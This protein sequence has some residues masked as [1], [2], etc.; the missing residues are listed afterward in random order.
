M[1]GRYS[2]S[3]PQGHVSAGQTKRRFIE[4]KG[5]GMVVMFLDSALAGKQTRSIAVAH[6]EEK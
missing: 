4:A 2:G 5:P 6:A 1:A 3:V